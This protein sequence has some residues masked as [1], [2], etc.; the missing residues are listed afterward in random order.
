[1]KSLFTICALSF[2]LGSSAQCDKNVIYNSG[3]ADFVDST[4]NNIRSKE[5][6]ITVT[7]T[8]KD[9]VLVH[10]DDEED[11]LRGDIK[12]FVCEWKD[13][14]K[15]GVTTFE[16]ELIEKS[17]EKNDAMVDRRTGWTSFDPDKF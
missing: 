7:L 6:K 12:N 10:D 1:M 8:K 3:K 15:N 11:A 2:S 9:F 4:G 16:S 5:G 17:G 14:W 13:A